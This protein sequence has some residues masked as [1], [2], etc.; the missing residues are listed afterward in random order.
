[1]KITIF[2]VSNAAC[3]LVV[4]PNGYSMMIDCGSHTD[5]E[6]PV[7][8]INEWK[9]PNKWLSEM[10]TFNNFPLTLLHIT[11]PDDDHVRNAKK[12]KDSLTPYLL[13][14]TRYEEFEEKP[15]VF[16]RKKIHDDYKNHVCKT[17]RG[18]PINI[19]SFWGFNTSTFQIPI[20]TIL[21][22]DDLNVSIANNSSII[23]WIELIG[24][25][26]IFRVLFC[27]DMEEAGWSWLIKNNPD[28]KNKIGKGIDILIAPHHGHNSGYSKELFEL[29]DAPKLSILSKGEES[30]GET[31]V[32]SNY[33][34]N[35]T[36]LLVTPLTTKISDRKY[37]LTTRSNGNIFIEINNMGIPS[38]WTSK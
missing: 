11:H 10:K 31:D 18:D 30:D 21:A 14:R 25:N 38:I 27:G 17:Y 15:P 19:D 13:L 6:C 12:V 36:G 37:S 29:M 16:R 3:A 24:T 26:Q 32:S 33:S 1:M 9:K 5:K 7:D 28:F 34:K 2:D 8:L 23:R 20:E 22:S 4:C 35:S